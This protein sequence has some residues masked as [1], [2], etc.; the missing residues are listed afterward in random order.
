MRH[1]SEA[2]YRRLNVAPSSRHVWRKL[3]LIQRTFVTTD[4]SISNLTFM[5]KVVE[6]MV[7]RQL[8]AYVEQNGLLTDLQSA[9]RRCRSTETGVLKVVADLLT[10]ADRG[11]VTLLSLLQCRSIRCF[12]HCWS[13]HPYRQTIS[14]FWFSWWC[15]V[16]DYQFRHWSYTKVLCWWRTIRCGPRSFAVSGPSTWNS[17]PASLRNCRL[18]SAFRREL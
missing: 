11:K 4:Q 9:Y 2:L 16:M 14:C 10:A 1:Y 8:V 5:S 18:P 6:R 7:C 12:W 17:L 15:S 3:V 13:W